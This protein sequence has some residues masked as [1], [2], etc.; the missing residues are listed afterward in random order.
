[1]FLISQSVVVLLVS[2]KVLRV[3][4]NLRFFHMTSFLRKMTMHESSLKLIVDSIF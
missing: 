4:T 2:A 3:E 1:M